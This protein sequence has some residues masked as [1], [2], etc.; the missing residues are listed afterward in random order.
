MFYD[1]KE[2]DGFEILKNQVVIDWGKGTLQWMQNWSTMKEVVRIDQVS[3]NE[4]IPYFT[5]YEDVLLNYSQLK[6]VVADNEWK[7]KLE[8]CNCVYV[9]TDKSNGKQYVG[10]TY[11]GSKAGIKG[12][13]LS[14]WTEY[15][16]TGHGEDMSLKKLCEEDSNYAEENFQ[17][18]ILETLPLSVIPAIAINI[19]TKWKEKLLTKTFGYNNN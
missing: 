11:K 2:V 13:I 9:I 14:R 16:N 19:E 5:R 3:D 1:L 6:Q 18:S 15:A 7:A 10:V 4:G 12:G 17:W 8:A